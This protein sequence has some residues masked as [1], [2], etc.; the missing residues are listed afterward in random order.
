MH[1]DNPKIPTAVSPLEPSQRGLV[2]WMAWVQRHAVAILVASIVLTAGALVH[3][4]EN[5]R[6]DTATDE[7][8]S[9]ELEF[10]R[11]QQAL[12]EAFP[13][14]SD[15]ILIV[16]DGQNRDRVATAAAGLARR[17]EDRPELF[18]GVF[19]PQ[20]EPFFRRNGLLYLGEEE[21]AA[22]AEELA[23]AQPLLASL[24]ADPSL[25]GLF[26]VLSLAV[27][28]AAE[29]P[30]TAEALASFLARV[31]E[32]AEAQAAGERRQL[33]W[34]SI[35]G[36][37]AEAGPELVMVQPV[38]DH[39][40]LRPAAEPIAA[41]RQLAA[42]IK[43]DGVRLRLT[44]GAALEQD[45]LRSVEDGMGLIGGVSL[46]L[47]ALL[48]FWGLGSKRLTS[49]ALA[50][51]AVGLAWTA[52]LAILAVGRLNLI[53]VA[54]AVLFIGLS[55]DFAIHLILRAREERTRF[56]IEGHLQRA[57][58]GVG[59]PLILS[60]AAAGIGFLSFVPTA[61]VGLAELGIIA[62]IGMA[63]AL[64]TNLTVLP[65]LI[66]VM[67]PPPREM[68]ARRVSAALAFARKLVERR[69]PSIAGIAVAVTLA[70][71][72][73]LPH[74]RFDF[75]PMNLRDPD[76]ESVATLRDL[77]TE[78]EV[79]PYAVAVLA[80]DRERA[81]EIEG[82]LEALPE[83][84]TVVAPADLVPS[85]QDE[86]LETIADLAMI[87][88][89]VFAPEPVPE[90]TLAERRAAYAKL[91]QDLRAVD[92]PLAGAAARLADG[93]AELEGATAPAA[94]TLR[95]LE[96]R[97]LGTL[98]P[99]LDDLRLSLAAEPV[100]WEDLPSAVR[101]R[102]VAPD[103][104]V[105]LQVIPAGDMRHAGE[106]R[107]FV[108]A[109]RSV[110]PDASGPPVVILAASEAVID[111]FRQATALALA[112]I[113]AL[114]LAVLRSLRETLLVLLPL[115]VAA[116]LTVAVSVVAELPFN[117]ANVIVLPLLFGL[118]VA[119]GIHFVLRGR[120]R[121]EGTVS[122]LETSTPRAIMFSA[123]TTT[124][125]FGSLSLSDHPGTASMGVLLTVAIAFTM[126]ATLTILPTAEA[127]I[128]RRK[129]RS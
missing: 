81:R 111:A 85:N 118:G 119:N 122:V 34:S 57:I 35:I 31:A 22:L 65:A 88:L 102:L 41:I 11:H 62:G 68:A 61:Y 53:S 8:L 48:L 63:V 95:E 103:G 72:A 66:T 20:S 45:E 109:V 67:P 19:H 129:R 83:V 91:R 128:A 56:G 32:V 52:A 9:E 99:R 39:G 55:V 78:D 59:K 104:R 58:A 7:M 5:L 108:A 25:R 123:L 80:A 73:M 17:L 115:S 117:F 51:L 33:S 76:S 42:E 92:G 12:K 84:E 106:L 2:L 16:L 70:A 37:E 46:S 126:L 89:P 47:V 124:A 50:T 6:I 97:L 94:E 110:A 29:S 90:P 28:N 82:R 116:V 101:E 18:R 54:F 27:G 127:L 13:Q 40:S 74:A 79:S 23:V 75:D 71:A 121:R 93:L 21:L 96:H 114:L 125:S 64:V 100:A 98:P 113:A 15:T 36:G 1:S 60:A 4:L 3:I 49:A 105:R 87:M 77:M 44:G 30:E 24:A 112:L 14:F 69:A 107:R 86:K 120:W 26:E 10:R 43:P 38:L